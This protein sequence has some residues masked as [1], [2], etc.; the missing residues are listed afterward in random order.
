M[1]VT[2]ARRLQ[3]DHRVGDIFFFAGPPGSTATKL[4]VDNVRLEA[5]GE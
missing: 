4:M 3:K 1:K 5:G 2:G